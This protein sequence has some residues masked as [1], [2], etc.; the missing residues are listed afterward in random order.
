MNRLPPRGA[1][2]PQLRLPLPLRR[3]DAAEKARARLL[4]PHSAR[5]S[6][7]DGNAAELVVREGTVRSGALARAL[8]LS[9]RFGP[10]VAFDYAPWLL[11]C[12]GIDVADA[13]GLHARWALA[14][15]AFAAVAP[16]LQAALGDP[17][18]CDASH[19]TPAEAFS[20][21]VDVS[22]R[23]PSIRLSMTLQTMP[24][25][26]GALLDSGPWVRT[27]PADPPPWLTS[28]R[29]AIPVAAGLTTLPLAEF[30][31]LAS[32][33]IVRVATTP[34]DVT[35]HATLR[36]ASRRLRVSWLVPYQ[37]FEVQ[38]M[39]PA[40]TSAPEG[41]DALEGSD[42]P[43]HTITSPTEIA[44]MADIPVRLSFSLGALSLTVGEIAALGRGSLLEVG[45]PLPPSVTIEANGQAV[46]AGELVDLDGRLAVEITRWPGCGTRSLASTS[47]STS[48]P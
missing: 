48:T 45:E 13:T 22:L 38:E 8:P 27:A 20:V 14:R 3:I 18:V 15:Y 11:A 6:L 16:S 2:A 34:F 9:T 7:P 1:L 4:H 40:P 35:G 42:A 23:L 26:L 12:T 21:A 37:C 30:R 29:A 33:D 39:L 19:S 43:A 24:A 44:E 10:A 28:I 31:A 5:C 46:G 25:T 17:V 47:T 32:G 41:S 36:V